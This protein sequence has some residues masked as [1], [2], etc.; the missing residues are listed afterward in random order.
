MSDP[1]VIF[2][3]SVGVSGSFDGVCNIALNVFM[4]TADGKEVVPDPRIVAQLRC[5]RA[6]AKDLRDNLDR[7][8]GDRPKEEPASEAKP[9]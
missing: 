2:F 3:N 8:L 1:K 5:T 6:A 7:I 9:N 4:F